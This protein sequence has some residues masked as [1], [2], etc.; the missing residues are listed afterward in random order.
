MSPLS[1]RGAARWQKSQLIKVKHVYGRWECADGGWCWVGSTL[2]GENEC[3]TAQDQVGARC[4]VAL[5]NCLICGWKSANYS[6]KE[7]RWAWRGSSSFTLKR[8]S[9]HCKTQT[10]WKKQH[11][12]FDGFSWLHAD[13]I[14]NLIFEGSHVRLQDKVVWNVKQIYHASCY[15][16]PNEEKPQ[17]KHDTVFQ[18]TYLCET[19]HINWSQ[20]GRKR[21]RN[22]NQGW[23]L[24]W[25]RAF[26][27]MPLVLISRL[28]P[29]LI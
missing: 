15:A 4:F 11:L 5:S 27:L 12:R 19:C 10:H 1:L 9:C 14:S 21:R 8:E 2:L 17:L 23:C 13:N 25:L 24:S 22:A 28:P 6:M 26:S 16:R 29:S 3:H 18:T 7:S 20:N